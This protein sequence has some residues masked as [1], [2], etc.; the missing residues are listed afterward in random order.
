MREKTFEAWT[1]T[2]EGDTAYRRSKARRRL[3]RGTLA[4]LGIALILL[5]VGWV[6]ADVQ[7]G[8]E[9]G[10]KAPPA[11]KSDRLRLTIPRLERVRE[12]PVY[13]GESGDKGKL[14]AGV[15][16]LED[17]GFPWQ[18]GSNVYIAGHRLG[19]PRTKSWLVFWRLNKL[20][21]GDKVILED[22]DGRRYKYEVFDKEVVDPDNS[23]VKKPVKGK[24]I[25]T[26][27]TCTLPDY[28]DRLIVRA[29]RVPNHGD[30]HAQA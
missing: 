24:S 7:K 30:Q 21:R 26:L 5:S 22:A 20:E 23:S 14:A 6:M 25:V 12:I 27:Q 1:R 2:A 29:E 3:G 10:A 18:A 9:A 8:E 16:H 11:P 4:L 28:K 19:Y 17:T 15:L 13:T